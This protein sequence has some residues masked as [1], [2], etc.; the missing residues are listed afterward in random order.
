MIKSISIWVS[1]CWFSAFIYLAPAICLAGNPS[2]NEAYAVTLVNYIRQN[3]KA[4][5]E[6]LGYNYNTLV[7]TLPWVV[8]YLSGMNPFSSSDFL[9]QR[10]T[11][12]NNM[13][14]KVSGPV[15]THY[16]D[17]AFTGDFGGVVSFVNYMDPGQAVKI[18]IN[19]QFKKELDPLYEG[20]RYILSSD[21]DLAGVSFK[22][23]TTQVKTGLRNAYFITLCF[24][25]SLLKSE[26]QIVNMINQ[27]RADPTDSFKYLSFNIPW[28]Q[29]ELQPLFFND[30][31]GL[32]AKTGLTS[33]IDFPAY[34]LY[35]GFSGT[36]VKESSIV[37]VFPAAEPDL[38]VRWLFSAFVL[39]EI[40]S[41]PS[42]NTIFNP[43]YNEIG[44]GIYYLTNS[45]YIFS[46]LT[47]ASGFTLKKD[48]S[49]VKIYGVVFTDSDENGC[50]TP[51]EEA[52]ERV[53]VAYDKKTLGKVA[54][55]VSNNA[56]QFVMELSADKEYVIQTGT[57]K[58]LSAKEIYLTT[59]R[60]FD[61]ALQPEK[62]IH[63]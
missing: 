32:T 19:S 61:L 51:G 53:M 12:L 9:N 11:A 35:F 26:V 46:K 4:Y 48:S 36:G 58:N 45:G 21:Y 6:T 34:A 57:D 27:L 14:V 25:S 54:T 7:K 2:G 18:V 30:A 40:K 5:A 20:K 63:K 47:T 56:G 15:P 29:G 59:N 37:E 16:T 33:L 24:G 1:L 62:N 22:V 44:M 3:P 39:G 50:Y 38:H 10:A 17:Y 60:F 55:A 8:P 13:D 43:A 41:Y 52:A 42:K 31:L 28:I 49:L 23:G